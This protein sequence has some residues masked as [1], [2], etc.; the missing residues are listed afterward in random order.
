MSD[1]EERA[2][3]VVG[4]MRNVGACTSKWGCRG[5]LQEWSD[6]HGWWIT[7]VVGVWRV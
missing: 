5:S 2:V 4:E 3:G 7:I 1:V 6:E